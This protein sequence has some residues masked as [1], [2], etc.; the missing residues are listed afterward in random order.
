[1]H[2]IFSSI[3]LFLFLIC[4]YFFNP[5]NVCVLKLQLAILLRL[6]LVDGMTDTKKIHRILV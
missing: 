4:K 6:V 5:T 3:I 2:I 1:M